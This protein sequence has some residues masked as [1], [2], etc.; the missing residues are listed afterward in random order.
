MKKKKKDSWVA[1]AAK[2]FVIDDNPAVV[3]DSCSS[4]T[5]L[6]WR[7]M[8]RQNFFVMVTLCCETD[9]ALCCGVL[10]VQLATFAKK[11][12]SGSVSPAQARM[13]RQ[14]T[15]HSF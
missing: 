14:R 3:L 7:C 12:Q 2:V 5:T 11:H 15:Y 13:D 10:Q 8:A 9:I 1:S 4:T 6:G